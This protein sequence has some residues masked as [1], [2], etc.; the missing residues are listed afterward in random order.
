MRG[1]DAGTGVGTARGDEGKFAAG[2]EPELATDGA[3]NFAS[4]GAAG[5]I[6]AAV[7]VAAL[8][9]DETG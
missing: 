1:G 8:D 7:A 2:A 6:R 4:G 5:A 3:D 9:A